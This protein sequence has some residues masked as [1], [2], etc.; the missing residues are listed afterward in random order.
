VTA[1]SLPEEG[2]VAMSKPDFA[3]WLRQRMEERDP[4]AIVRFG[5]AEAKLLTAD[6][7]DVASMDVAIAKFHKETGLSLSPAAVLEVQGLVASAF[8]QADVLGIRF[9]RLLDEHEMWMDKLAALH[10]GSVDAGRRPAALAHCLLNYDVLDVLPE[11]LAGRRI[12][13][14]SCRDVKPVLEAGEPTTSLPTRCLLTTRLRDVDGP[15]EAALHDVPIWP[16]AH[17][18]IRSELQVRE[19]GEVF[20]VGAGLFGKDLCIR[21]REQG[22]IALDMG[23]ALDR[24][25]GKVTRGGKRRVLDLYV[26]G[27][28]VPDIA[29]HLKEVFGLETDHDRISEILD[30]AVADFAAW[31]ERPLEPVYPTVELGALHVEIGGDGVAERRVCCLATGVADGGR[32]ELGIWWGSSE[33]PALW[34]AVL[35]DLRERGVESIELA[36]S[37]GAP[38]LSDAIAAMFPNTELQAAGEG[39]HRQVRK[40]IATRGQFPDEQDATRL[41]RLVTVRAMRR[42]S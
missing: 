18:R 22:G 36:R 29:A 5:D 41:I 1:A 38:G 39:V 13:V 8:D 14:I 42:R 28:S 23:S 4:A 25:A 37:D 24:I 30:Q 7:G 33:D 15:Y 10:A 12:S 32:H 19:R 16:D 27:M 3:R 26:G 17:A 21:I 35:R 9:Y 11:L 6:P 2:S 40:A 31:N 20:L 34:P